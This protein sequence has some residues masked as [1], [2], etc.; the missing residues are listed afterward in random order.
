MA[1]AAF[2]RGHFAVTSQFEILAAL[3]RAE[4]ALVRDMPG[5]LHLPEDE[6]NW[7]SLAGLAWHREHIFGLGG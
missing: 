2:Q 7:P 5:V 6:R 4:P 1:A 3:G